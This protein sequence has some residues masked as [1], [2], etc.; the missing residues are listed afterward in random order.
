MHSV[1]FSLYWEQFYLQCCS[2]YLRYLPHGRSL[3]HCVCLLATLPMLRFLPHLL[4]LLWPVAC[5]SS[6]RLPTMSVS[7]LRCLLPSLSL[8]PCIRHT[9]SS[10]RPCAFCVI[11]RDTCD[12]IRTRSCSSTPGCLRGRISRSDRCGWCGAPKTATRSTTR[13]STP[14]SQQKDS[15]LMW[16]SSTSTSST[17]R[18]WICTS[19]KADSTSLRSGRPTSRSTLVLL[20]SALLQFDLI[21]L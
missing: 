13:S 4:V 7:L 18:R 2:Y 6:C 8:L 1:C 16:I 3:H 19:D 12:A 10:R 9:A 17:R 14:L 21:L 15:L 11:D 5:P 20:L